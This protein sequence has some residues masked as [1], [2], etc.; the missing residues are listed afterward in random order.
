MGSDGPHSGPEP[1]SGY[2]LRLEDCSRPRPWRD[3]RRR[4]PQSLLERPARRQGQRREPGRSASGKRSIPGG[5]PHRKTGG[6]N[7]RFQG[8]GLT[9]RPEKLVARRVEPG[10]AGRYSTLGAPASCRPLTRE[11]PAGSG[12]HHRSRRDVPARLRHPPQ[13][14][15]TAERLRRGNAGTRSR[16]C[17]GAGIP[18]HEIA[19]TARVP[20]RRD[21]PPSPW[22]ADLPNERRRLEPATGLAV[23]GRQGN[24]QNTT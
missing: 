14:T 8:R 18:H 10:E 17:N 15:E 19:M 12:P 11:E 7:P 6:L 4:N 5:A 16:R 20:L 24:R 13:A 3:H 9:C 21:V 2:G 22:S 23:R 1:C